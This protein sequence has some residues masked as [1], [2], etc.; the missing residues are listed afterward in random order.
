MDLWEAIKG[1]RSARA[2]TSDPVNRE[3]VDELI[4]AATWAPSPLHLQPWQFV[5]ITGAEARDRVKATAQAALDRVVAAG[6][7]VWAGKYSFAF[8][9]Q[10]PVLVAV[11]YDPAKGGL[12]AYFNQSQGALCAAAA[13]IQNLMLAAHARG[14]ASL[15]LTFFDPAEMRLALGAPEG[16]EVAGVIPL[17]V[18]AGELK[19]P[20][21]KPAKVFQETCGD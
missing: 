12:G 18:A 9:D 4:E 5:V 20:P 7:P 15:W 21:R 10:A 16:L 6:G 17:G 3:V 19:P 1:R 2:F 13:A 14:L 11:L 8:L